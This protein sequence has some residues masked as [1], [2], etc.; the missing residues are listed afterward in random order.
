MPP[1]NPIDENLDE[2]VNTAPPP[3]YPGSANN[4]DLTPTPQSQNRPRLPESNRNERLND[5]TCPYEAGEGILISAVTEDVF[6]VKFQT[7]VRD[8]KEIIIGRVKVPTVRCHQ[9]PNF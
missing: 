2:L 5:C 3:P 4:Y 8:G 1:V 6:I 9:R 7:I